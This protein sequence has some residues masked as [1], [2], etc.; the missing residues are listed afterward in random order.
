MVVGLAAGALAVPVTFRWWSHPSYQCI[1]FPLLEMVRCAHAGYAVFLVTMYSRLRSLPITLG[2]KTHIHFTL[3]LAFVAVIFA[4]D[5]TALIAHNANV[6]S[7]V[8][9]ILMAISS[10]LCVGWIALFSGIWQKVEDIPRRD[11]SPEVLARLREM[12][13]VCNLLRQKSWL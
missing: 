5:S 1:G 4:G 6:N 3:W 9:L 11:P 13:E 12:N 7:V 2:I 8:S 10:I